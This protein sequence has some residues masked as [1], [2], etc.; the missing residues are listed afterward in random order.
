MRSWQQP[1][2]VW[3]ISAIFPFRIDQGMA[4]FDAT[5]E[6]LGQDSEFPIY[7][8]PD[9]EEE[10]AMALTREE[11]APLRL[12]RMMRQGHFLGENSWNFTDD[13]LWPWRIGH[14]VCSSASGRGWL[15]PSCGELKM[16]IWSAR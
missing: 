4:T 3:G 16:A 9:M 8:E 5:A 12:M 1:R 6:L 10:A 14:E 2:R 7:D 15:S 11:K 13:Q